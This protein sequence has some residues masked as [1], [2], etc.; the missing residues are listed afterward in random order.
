MLCDGVLAFIKAYRLKGD[1]FSLKSKVAERFDA[2]LVADA[3]KKLWESCNA[4]LTRAGLSYHVQRSSERSCQLVADLEDILSAF[5]A[6]DAR[7]ELPDIFCEATDLLKLPP[8][9]LDPVSCCWPL[10]VSSN[11]SELTGYFCVKT[12]PLMCVTDASHYVL[13]LAYLLFPLPLPTLSL[14]LV[15]VIVALLI[16]TLPGI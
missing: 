12:Y 2:S 6:L 14:F 5:E 11:S 16:M 1:N 7:E 4:L 10:K 3:K 9:C 15:V 13:I 8:I